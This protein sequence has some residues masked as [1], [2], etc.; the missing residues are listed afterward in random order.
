MK[1]L[2]KK[3]TV[4]SKKFTKDELE[5]IL[6]NNIDKKLIKILRG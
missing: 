6:L 4:K 5:W 1:S 2:T 3:R